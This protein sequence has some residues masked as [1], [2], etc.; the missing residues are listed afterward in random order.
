MRTTVTLE[1]D[2]ARGIRDRMR[3]RDAGFKETVND[4]LRRGLVADAPRP[5]PY[6]I[7]V[8]DSPIRAGIDLDKAVALAGALEDDE[9]LRKLELGK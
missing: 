7:E 2:V 1:T 9:L 4:L 5:A 3:E 8:F 6:E